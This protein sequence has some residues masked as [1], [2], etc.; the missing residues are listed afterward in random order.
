M[1]SLS[2]MLKP[3]KFKS[4]IIYSIK[5]HQ[6]VCTIPLLLIELL[7]VSQT[8]AVDLR[9]FIDAVIGPNFVCFPLCVLK[10][11]RANALKTKK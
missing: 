4:F 5:T 10:G 9:G 1:Y 2:K 7:N 6:L 8:E 3:L 11:A